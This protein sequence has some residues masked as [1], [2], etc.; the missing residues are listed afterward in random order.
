MEKIIDL[1]I[2]HIGEQIFKCLKLDDLVHCLEVS[3]TW[4]TLA[5]SALKGKMFEVCQSGKTEIVKLLLENYNGEESGLNFKNAL[6]RTLFL[7][8]CY[9]GHK[10]VVKLL[11]Y[12]NI[13]LNAKD[14]YGRTQSW[15]HS[16]KNS[17]HNSYWTK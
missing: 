11:L 10:D 2:P 12:Q 15:V 6:S 17:I 14:I 4:K 7:V 9:E 16:R 5:L 8:A 13:D 3:Q 1:G